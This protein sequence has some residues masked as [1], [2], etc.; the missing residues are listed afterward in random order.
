MKNNVCRKVLKV[1]LNMHN[2]IKSHVMQ[3]DDISGFLTRE[4]FTNRRDKCDSSII[5]WITRITLVFVDYAYCQYLW[6]DYTY[7]PYLWDDYTYCPYFWDDNTYCPY[8]MK[9]NVCRKVLKVILNMHNRIKSHVMQNDDISGFLTCDIGCAKGK[10][11]LEY[12]N[13]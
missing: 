2:R 5:I 10:I 1:I 7:C 6:D 8:L 13:F 11:Y 3:N 9:N 12:L 4:D